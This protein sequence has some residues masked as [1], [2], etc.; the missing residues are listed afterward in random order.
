M[1]KTNEKIARKVET[2]MCAATLILVAL[3]RDGL[4]TG[5]AWVQT[6]L[7]VLA[8]MGLVRNTDDTWT[9]TRKGAAVANL[10]EV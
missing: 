8:G 3:E 4:R 5:N 10:V 7:S 9:V 6:N 2:E 1:T